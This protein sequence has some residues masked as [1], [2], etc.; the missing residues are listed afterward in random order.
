MNCAFLK[1]APKTRPQEGNLRENECV[2]R[3]FSSG[4]RL[5]RAHELY[6]SCYHFL[7]L[8]PREASILDLCSQAEN[9]KLADMET[10]AERDRWLSLPF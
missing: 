2:N 1:I 5:Q 4:F 7:A 10:L 3:Y 8:S 9:D 6:F